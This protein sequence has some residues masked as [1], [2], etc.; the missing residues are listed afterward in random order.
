M[1]RDDVDV[2]VVSPTPVTFGYGR[3]AHEALE[4]AK[5]VNDA[6]IELRDASGGRIVTLCQVPLQD[7]DLACAELERAVTAGHVGVEIGNHV[8]D[9]ELDDKAVLAFLECCI[10]LDV[11]ILVH[12]WDMRG[13]D[14]LDRF[15]LRWT[16][17]MPAETHLGITTM[18]LGGAFDRFD[19]SLRIASPTAAAASPPSSDGSTSPGNDAAGWRAV[20][21]S[22]LPATI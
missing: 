14:S 6:G 20:T 10:D 7:V 2:Q 16:V 13:P 4:M 19:E 9:Q 18:I 8:G 22:D 12:P 17:G 21:P 1:D 5:F 15:M 11:A 3:P